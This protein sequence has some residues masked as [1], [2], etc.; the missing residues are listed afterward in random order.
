[1]ERK[2]MKSCW[3]WCFSNRREKGETSVGWS[4]FGNENDEE[5]A[6]WSVLGMGRNEKC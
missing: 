5:M 2:K 6:D 1:M 4:C 3:K